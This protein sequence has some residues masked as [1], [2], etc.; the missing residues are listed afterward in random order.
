MSLEPCD[1][2]RAPNGDLNIIAN[3]VE[4]IVSDDRP[5]NKYQ[6]ILASSSIEEPVIKPIEPPKEKKPWMPVSPRRIE[7]QQ[8]QQKR[9]S[10]NTTPYAKEQ[11]LTSK[12]QT[13]S[14]SKSPN[15]R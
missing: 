13:H 12:H 14:P 4:T 7:I 11:T 5:H 10:K 15:K 1:A 8:S 2:E 3:P 6:Q 9:T